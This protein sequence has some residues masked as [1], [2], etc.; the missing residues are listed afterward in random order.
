M[1]LK[2]GNE[3][4]PSILDKMMG[5]RVEGQYI[6]SLPASR[7]EIIALQEEVEC[8]LRERQAKLVGFCPIRRELYDELFLEVIRQSTINCSERGLLLLRL[9][10]ELKMSMDSLLHVY[11]SAI[12]YSNRPIVTTT[13]QCDT[14]ELETKI[15]TLNSTLE[16]EK[17]KS[18]QTIKQLED[19]I[20]FLK[21]LNLSKSEKE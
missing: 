8:K 7:N 16:E 4:Q 17:F 20:V 10:D 14:T 18:K 3:D 12:Q 15:K 13:L 9:K 2:F 6:S 11:Q 21:K 1:L 19:E 5:S